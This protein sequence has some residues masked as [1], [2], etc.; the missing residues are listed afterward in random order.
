MKSS[1][2]P[3]WNTISTKWVLILLK[4]IRLDVRQIR[5]SGYTTWRWIYC[6]MDVESDKFSCT[7]DNNESKKV[8]KYAN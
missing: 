3:I 4:N 7:S 6:H 8:F 2:S 1:L 5:F